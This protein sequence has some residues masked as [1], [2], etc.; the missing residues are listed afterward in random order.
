ML[1]LDPPSV[2][3]KVADFINDPVKP[4]ELESR[5]VIAAQQV[6]TSEEAL[7]TLKVNF[8]QTGKM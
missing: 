1:Q 3:V 2:I 8:L 5:L 6:A 7:A 4:L